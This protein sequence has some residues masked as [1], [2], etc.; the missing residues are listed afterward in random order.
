MP[1]KAKE[2][3]SQEQLEYDIFTV[4]EP[5]EIQELIRDAKEFYILNSKC[6]DPLGP[7]VDRHIKAAADALIKL[8]HW[9][10]QLAKVIKCTSS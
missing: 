4:F 1:K 3:K 6:L 8:A 10:K 2:P 5:G 9:H 7:N